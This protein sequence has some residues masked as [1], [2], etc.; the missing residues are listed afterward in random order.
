MSEYIF[1]TNIFEYPNIQIYSSHSALERCQI[2]NGQCCQFFSSLLHCVF[3]F[4]SFSN[5]LYRI[6]YGLGTL[7]RG[8]KW[9]WTVLSIF[10]FLSF[11]KKFFKSLV[12][13][14]LCSPPFPMW[15][16]DSLERCQMEVDS[17]NVTLGRSYQPP[18]PAES[19]F[20][21]CVAGVVFFTFL[22]CVFFTFLH[23]V[24]QITCIVST[25]LRF[26]LL[27]V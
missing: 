18:P 12:A 20:Q 8:V 16:R 17:W 19:S 1:V 14:Q 13:Y 2:E 7:Q 3:F 21:H 11:F 22:H 4:K 9:K 25:A 23:C 6:N 24:F 26:K 10:S 5:H 15:T 27:M